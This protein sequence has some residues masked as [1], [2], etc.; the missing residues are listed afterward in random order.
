MFYTVAPSFVTVFRSFREPSPGSMVSVPLVHR[1]KLL[2]NHS[3]ST[4][5]SFSVT[6]RKVIEFAVS[7]YWMLPYE[8][9][10]VT[11]SEFLS[12]TMSEK[13]GP[14]EAK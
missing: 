11:V 12:S 8:A 9:P 2:T 5:I 10:S 14:S 7:G 13:E 1:P 4:S 3:N 6:C